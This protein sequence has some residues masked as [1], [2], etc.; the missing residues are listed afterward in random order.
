[1]SDKDNTDLQPHIAPPE[2]APAGP[3]PG[4]PRKPGWWKTLGLWMVIGAGLGLACARMLSWISFAPAQDPSTS[5]QQEHCPRPVAPVPVAPAA[6]EA[7]PADVY[8]GVYVANIPSLSI[9]DNRF[10]SDLWVWFRWADAE[11]KPAETFEVVGGRISNRECKSYGL[12]QGLNY[13]LCKISV[14]ATQLFDVGMFPFDNQQIQVRIE[15]KDHEA[16]SLRYVA[17]AENC[18]VDRYLN[19][20][21]WRLDKTVAQ[22]IEQ[23]YCSNFGDTELASGQESTYSRF[24]YTLGFKRAGITYF[25]KL[26]IALFVATA[27]ALLALWIKPTDIDPRFGLGS[28]ALFATVANEYVIAGYLPKS[29]VISTADALHIV[30]MIVI[31][32]TLIE[33]TISLSIYTRKTPEGLDSEA[34][35]ILSR[36]LDRLFFGLLTFA[37]L[38]LCYWIAR[39]A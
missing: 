21:G 29:D 33:S 20:P 10:D 35:Q 12:R 19:V 17:D 4:G 2:K 11:L 8:V 22:V 18:A 34:N 16:D 36:R 9:R 30:S 28:A 14:Q 23:R 3:P 39:G 37:F 13:D 1:M 38:G 26:L 5:M 31:L 32:F 6:Q 25:M 7:K 27:I 24:V 15:D